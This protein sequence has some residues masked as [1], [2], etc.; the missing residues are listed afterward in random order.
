MSNLYQRKLS[1][2]GVDVSA[3]SEEELRSLIRQILD[4]GIHGICFS[5]YVGTQGPGTALDA[6]Q[7]RERMTT[8]SAPQPPWLVSTS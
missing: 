7:I 6:A 4:D 1:L 5:P 3:L 2:A 8:F